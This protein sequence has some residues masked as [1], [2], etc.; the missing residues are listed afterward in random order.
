VTNPLL[1]IPLTLIV[2]SDPDQDGVDSSVQDAG[3]NGGDGIPDSAQ[4]DVATLSVAGAYVTVA[5]DGGCDATIDIA[6]GA[7]S[8]GHAVADGWRPGR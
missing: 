6:A 5:T 8:V 4:S 7:C 1:K 2:S 3:P